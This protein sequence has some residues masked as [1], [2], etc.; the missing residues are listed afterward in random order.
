LRNDFDL[1]VQRISFLTITCLFIGLI[2]GN[3]LLILLLGCIAYIV[4]TLFQMRQLEHWLRNSRQLSVPDAS[5]IWGN[6]F[7]HLSREKKRQLKEKKRLKTV[8]NRVETMTA[9]LNDAVIL[10]SKE[11]TINW[12]NK[13]SRHL[14][15]LKKTDV[16]N[17][18]TN[19]IRNPLWVKYLN[20]GD[21]RIP[22]TL[23]SS[24]DNEQRLEFR[25][26]LFGDGEGLLI[27]RDVTRLYKLEQMRK[28]F[29]ANVSHEL[30]TP[31]TVILGYLET[32]NDSL[33]PDERWKKPVQ[34]MQEQA[35]RMTTLINDLTMLS[36]LETDEINN[37]QMAVHLL[38]LLQ[39]ITDEART[40]SGDK[41]HFITLECPQEL[42]LIGNDRELHSAFSNLIM[43][44][45][46]YSPPQKPIAIKVG[47]NF[48]GGVDVKVIDEGL[49]I[50]QHHINRLTERFYRVD[51]SRSIETGGTGLGLAIVK[52]ILARH[53]ARLNISSRIN[54]GSTFTA[55]FPR[56]RVED[57]KLLNED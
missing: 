3:I 42:R 10:L 43:N 24:H 30:R 45:V 18:I 2:A 48:I 16:G 23:P 53:N 41:K 29:V 5:G 52:H 6:I 12:L 1:E 46:K 57:P 4:W 20:E 8:I 56:E 35:S 44:A 54:Q 9:S 28:D 51:S 33:N 7:D 39:M 50:E 13:S 40:V 49:G 26:N 15:N 37:K 47:K 17:P 36:K 34:Q 19:F 55:I 25:I 32:L 38:P 31:L 27:V 11:Q 21:Y 22:L 14:L